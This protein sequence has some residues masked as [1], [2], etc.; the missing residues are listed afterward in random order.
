MLNMILA[1]DCAWHDV[2]SQGFKVLILKA[3]LQEAKHGCRRMQEAVSVNAM[4]A[5]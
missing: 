1:W 3:A 5:A 4:L 2:R